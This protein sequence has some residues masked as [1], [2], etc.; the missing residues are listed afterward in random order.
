MYLS[1]LGF[2]LMLAGNVI[3]V[4][5]IGIPNGYIG[6]AWAALIA[7]A[8]IMTASYFLG[9]KYYPIPYDVRRI[10]AYTLLAAILWGIGAAC[11]FTHAMWSTYIIRALLLLIYL[12]VVIHFENIPVLSSRL[13]Q[14]E[15]RFPIRH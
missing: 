7:Y 10:G 13:H 8:G 1:L 6:S 11:S 15:R 3:L 5:M 12:L 2:V 9:R 14:F 4:P